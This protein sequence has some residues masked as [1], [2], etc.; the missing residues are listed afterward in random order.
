MNRR[1]KPSGQDPSDLRNTDPSHV[2]ITSLQSGAEQELAR[3]VP[4]VSERTPLP[5][6]KANLQNPSPPWNTPFE[7]LPSDWPLLQRNQAHRPRRPLNIH[8][9]SQAA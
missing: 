7:R 2:P 6:G 8:R 4:C 9:L 1:G 5:I 3:V